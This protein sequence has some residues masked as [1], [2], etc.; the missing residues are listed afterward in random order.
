MSTTPPLAFDPEQF[1][2][3]RTGG[4]GARLGLSYHAHGSDW[5]DFTLPYDPALIGDPDSGV[6]ASGPILS[7]MDVATSM[8]VWLKLGEFRP[9]ATLDLRVDYL[10]PATPG[11]TVVG[12][13]E[14]YRITR[15]IAFVRGQAHDGDP[16]DPLAHVAGT[17]MALEGYF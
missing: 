9:H 13:G 15:S 12:R 7:M 3:D 10:R 16:T 14:C 4:H 5:V 17:F 1:L 2:Q 8:A 11:K 6:I